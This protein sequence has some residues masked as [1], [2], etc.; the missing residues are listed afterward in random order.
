ME[1]DGYLQ[2]FSLPLNQ[3]HPIQL[4]Y[5]LLKHH[6]P[7]W[8]P[9]GEYIAFIGSGP[10]IPYQLYL[11]T[12][13][14]S[15]QVSVAPDLVDIMYPAWS[16]KGNYLSFSGRDERGNRNIYALSLQD[17]S[18]MQISFPSQEVEG[19]HSPEVAGFESSWSADSSYLAIVVSPDQVR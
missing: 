8:S 3:T 4:T 7:L 17:G 16:S 15:E 9:D 12:V 10:E 11:L 6:D 18:R 19:M 13:N 2:I 1:Q 5:N 14:T